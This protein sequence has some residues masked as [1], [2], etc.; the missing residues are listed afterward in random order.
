MP[1]TRTPRQP[2]TPRQ[3]VGPEYPGVAFS[4]Q[5]DAGNVQAALDALKASRKVRVCYWE[6]RADRDDP[7]KLR[8]RGNLEIV[9]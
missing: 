7:A 5:G 2:R 4:L 8:G 6:A 9:L 3:S 1:D